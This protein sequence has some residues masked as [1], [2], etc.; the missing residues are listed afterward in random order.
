[1]DAFPGIISVVIFVAVMVSNSFSLRFLGKESV[2]SNTNISAWILNCALANYLHCL[3]ILPIGIGFYSLG[4]QDLH[5]VE[6]IWMELETPFSLQFHSVAFLFVIFS[7]YMKIQQL[8]KIK[9]HVL[10]FLSVFVTSLCFMFPQII[11]RATNT[12][13]LT[14]ATGSFDSF[15]LEKSDSL[16]D[17]MLLC[18]AI[19]GVLLPGFLIIVCHPFTK[20]I[21]LSIQQN[22]EKANMQISENGP[23]AALTEATDTRGEFSRIGDQDSN[24]IELEYIMENENT[25]IKQHE[26]DKEETDKH[27]ETKLI[28]FREM[29]KRLRH[30]GMMTS[31]CDNFEDGSEEDNC[32]YDTPET[33]TDCSMIRKFYV[34]V[35]VHFLFWLP[36]L[37]AELANWSCQFCNVSKPAMFLVTLIPCVGMI[38]TPAMI[39]IKNFV[40]NCS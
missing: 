4:L 6:D 23:N 38:F 24:D 2:A 29:Q 20:H 22:Q 27:L 5:I 37:G 28:Q 35:F 34:N 18:T 39:T 11:I 9:A 25:D 33:D 1:M 15:G 17:Y 32:S 40:G 7:E 3:F 14:N 10:I 16:N 21:F 12:E 13:D 30:C 19:T 8:S 31:S 26:N 36:W